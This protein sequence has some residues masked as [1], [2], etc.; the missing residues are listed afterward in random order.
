MVRSHEYVIT[1]SMHWL[2]G[3]PSR[4]STPTPPASPSPFS[5][6]DPGPLRD[7]ELQLVSPHPQWIPD[8]LRSCHHP[9][10]RDLDPE[11]ANTDR[12]DLERLIKTAP[13]GKEPADPARGRVP[14]YHFWMRLQ[15]SGNPVSPDLSSPPLSIVGLINFRVSHSPDVETYFGHFGYSVFPP[16]RGNHYAERAC[17]LLLPLARAH[18][19]RTIWITTGPENQASRRT[20]ERLGARLVD[21]IDVPRNHPLYA[22]GQLRKCRYRIDLA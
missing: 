3:S 11:W 20:C 2:T 13:D 8:L 15:P 9:M 18:G 12:D 1:Q 10:T 22:R 21:V 14:A 17:R 7:R 16:A 5:F 4:P 6:L 19:F